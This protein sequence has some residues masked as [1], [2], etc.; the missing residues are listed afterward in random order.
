MSNILIKR[1]LIY[2]L[3]LVILQIPMLQNWMF[4]GVAFPFQY[5]GL[6]ILLPLTMNRAWTML[7][8]FFLG[9]LIDVFSNTPGMHTMASVLIGYTRLYWVGIV[10][11]IN[12]EELDLNI[13]HLGYFR[14]FIL[15]APLVLVHHFLLFIL[16]NEGF[17]SGLRLVGKTFWSTV[18]SSVIILMAGMLTMTQRRK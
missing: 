17:T 10:A 3:L 1:Y 13:S 18:A 4:F 15:I 5:V 2:L 14:F 12:D 6:I 9:L 11:D 8:A 16:E 7:I